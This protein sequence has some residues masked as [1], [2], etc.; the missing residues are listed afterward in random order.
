MARSP[1][2]QPRRTA[3]CPALF[4]KIE[5]W[6]NRLPGPYRSNVEGSDYLRKTTLYNLY[7]TVLGFRPAY[8]GNFD[9]K[10]AQQFARD[11]GVQ[12]KV[13][14]Y[15]D[16]VGRDYSYIVNPKHSRRFAPLFR[17]LEETYSDD[18]EEMEAQ[19]NQRAKLIGTILGFDVCLWSPGQ[20]GPNYGIAFYARPKQNPEERVEI[21]AYSCSANNIDRAVDSAVQLITKAMPYVD[22]CGLV[23]SFEVDVGL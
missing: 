23:L 21:F 12:A 8:L 14:P 1:R 6:V 4:R 7:F 15:F 3:T 17:K 18:E 10:N 9:A 16:V 13:G 20:K 22:P 5:R 11:F 2:A 19:V